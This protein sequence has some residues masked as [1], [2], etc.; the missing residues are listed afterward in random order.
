[1]EISGFIQTLLTGLKTSYALVD[2]AGQIIEHDS[3]VPVWAMGEQN[4][5]VGRALLNVLP[6]LVGQE[7]TLEKVGRREALFFRLENINRVDAAGKMRY[8]TLIAIPGGPRAGVALTV[9]ATDTTEQGE[10]LQELMQNRNELWLT[11]RKLVKLNHQLDYLLHHYLAPEVSY[12]L[13]QKDLRPELG[14][15]LRQVSILFAGVCSFTPLAEKLS[16]DHVVRLLND[17]LN[18]IAQA[19]DEVDGTIS[20]FQGDNVMV[21]FNASANQP[22]HA[23]RAVQAGIALQQTVAVYR[24]RR[25]PEELRL[26]FGVGINSGPALVGNIGTRWRYS[27]TAIGDTIN[28]AARITATVPPGEVWISQATYEQLQGAIA[29]EPLPPLMFKGK[30]EPTSLLR[31]CL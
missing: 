23:Q 5:L 31:I 19:V 15:E 22:D 21:M 1:M 12:P 29:V 4:S 16:P 14:G 30:S 3:L 2:S 13:R 28:L 8:L 26:H 18:I 20:Q 11:R 17:Y 6:E 25:P 7:E 24:T 10:Y 9:L 27:Y